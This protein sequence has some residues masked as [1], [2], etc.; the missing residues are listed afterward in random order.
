MLFFIVRF[1]LLFM[2]VGVDH[3]DSSGGDFHITNFFSCFT[4]K[5]SVA[6]LTQ[7]AYKDACT[8]TYIGTLEKSIRTAEMKT[9]S[10]FV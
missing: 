9:E 2:V 4:F 7:V 5:I 3:G 10:V 8:H 1:I 6:R